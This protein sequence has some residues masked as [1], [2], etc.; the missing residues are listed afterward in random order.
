MVEFLPQQH[1]ELAASCQVLQE[2]QATLLKN[3]VPHV[4]ILTS[5]LNLFYLEVLYYPQQGKNKCTSRPSE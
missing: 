1:G 4:I 5:Q 3:L 2:K